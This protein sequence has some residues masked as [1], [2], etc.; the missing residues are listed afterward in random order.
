MT[1]HS[2]RVS[3][4]QNIILLLMSLNQSDHLQYKQDYLYLTSYS[5][6]RRPFIIS[7]FLQNIFL[8]PS[9]QILA[10]S[11]TVQD[12]KSS[13][14]PICSRFQSESALVLCRISKKSSPVSSIY[15]PNSSQSSGV[16]G[17]AKKDLKKH[18]LVPTGIPQISFV[19]V[20]EKHTFM[21]AFIFFNDKPSVI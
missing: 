21:I 9:G 6:N 18:R 19:T 13:F 12:L 5:S 16:K 8:R 7:S 10:T 1:A 15:L 2:Q 4:L 20:D 14:C 11:E 3:V 17:E